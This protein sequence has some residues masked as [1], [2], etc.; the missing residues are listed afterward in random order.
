MPRAMFSAVSISRCAS[1]SRARSSSQYFRRRK[2][3]N[4]MASLLLS[5][6]QD[7]VARLDQPIPAARLLDQLLAAGRRKPVI[8][9]L[10]I[11]L[12]GSPER[13][14]PAPVLQ[15]MQSGIE[16]SVLHLENVFRAML[17]GVGDRVSVRRAEYQSLQNKQVQ[18]TLQH[19][20]FE[21]MSIHSFSILP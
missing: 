6:A 16:R 21:R 15:A 9:G 4:P 14:N 12:R 19:L 11:V 2:R 8:A 1:T 7:R 18:R 13:G 3:L 5:R 17:D 10:A 20:T